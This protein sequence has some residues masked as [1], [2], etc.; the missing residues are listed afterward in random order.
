LP[1]EL[2]TALPGSGKTEACIQ[3]IRTTLSE[4]PLAQV[5]I[6]VPDRLQAAAFRHRL[7][8]AG[9]VL[10]GYVGTFRD[11]YRSILE[12]SGSYFPLA[13]SSLLHRLVQE[14]VDQSIAMGE[15]KHYAALQSSPGFL[16]AL[17]DSF[18]ELKR[19]LILPERFLKFTENG[20][21]AQQEL[22]VL[23]A[24][25]QARLREL[26]W[27]DLEGLSWLAVEA[28]ESQPVLTSPIRLVVV[29]GFDSFTGVRRRV[30][31][32]LASR[33]DDLLITIPGKPGSSRPAHRHFT[34]T[35]E[36]LRQDL[37]PRM[38]ILENPPHLP[39]DIL[40]LENRI[41]ETG[42]G[43]IRSAAAPFLLEVRSPAEE[44]REALRW[45]KA[46]VI[47]EN[48]PLTDCAIFTHS[49]DVYQPLLRA[50]TNEFGMPIHFTQT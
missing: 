39:P 45:I 10:G 15:I 26:N 16:L 32:L 46:C 6:V 20:S 37:S 23:Y 35:I 11:L 22:A 27:A 24:H 28:L 25:Y 21:V 34:P 47:R 42:N 36:A 44:A 5:W 7:A 50:S 48:I 4:H 43:S 38:T 19:S 31:Q 13:S 30:L 9:G 8:A 17:Q 12:Q 14:T 18:A 2:L 29:D 49:P 3:R 40:Q 1:V 41:F 33:V